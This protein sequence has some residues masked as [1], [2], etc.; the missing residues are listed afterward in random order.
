VD[1]RGHA[2]L[3]ANA[4]LLDRYAAC[5]TAQEVIQV[6][7]SYLEHL[8]AKPPPEPEGKHTILPTPLAR[9]S[10]TFTGHW[11]VGVGGT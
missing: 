10:L 3:S 7:T 8:Q 6:Q 2:F 5:N 1:D 11:D 4:D 9:E